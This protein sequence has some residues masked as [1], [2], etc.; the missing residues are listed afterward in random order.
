MFIAVGNDPGNQ[1]GS[2]IYQIDTDGNLTFEYQPAEQGCLIELLIDPDSGDLIVLGIDPTQSW[3]LGN[4]YHRSG[5]GVWTK[6]RNMTNVIHAIGGCFHDNGDLYVGVGAHEGDSSSWEGRIFR[7]DDLGLTW[8]SVLVSTYRQYSV[9]SFNGNLY[10]IAGYGH[11]TGAL[12]WSDDDGDSWA[13]IV[14][15][16]V[17]RH[18]R[19]KVWQN[20]LIMIK[21]NGGVIYA[22]DT[23]NVVSTN[24]APPSP[25]VKD[26]FNIM[27]VEGNWLYV[28]TEAG[29]YRTDDL[30]TW[31]L[32]AIVPDCVSLLLWPGEFF[33]V[34]EKGTSARLLK[35]PLI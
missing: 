27:A 4:T 5:A 18:P 28:L 3:A 15:L 33:I 35:I 24:P 32:Y 6:N 19:P 29:I 7:S 11:P 30:T 10:S 21:E 31:R 13:E 14:G 23:S 2:A 22:V 9:V 20:Q 26:E 12:F 16:G 17:S 8:S 34:S 25:I 1:N